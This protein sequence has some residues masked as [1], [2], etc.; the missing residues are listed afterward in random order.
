MKASKITS[1][2]VVESE[3][4]DSES[5]G[6]ESVRTDDFSEDDEDDLETD[7]FAK[8]SMAAKSAAPESGDEVSPA[9]PTTHTFFSYGKTSSKMPATMKIIFTGKIH[10]KPHELNMP[11]AY[12]ADEYFQYVD[13]KSK[14]KYRGLAHQLSG[15]NDVV[16]H[17]MTFA[18]CE[19]E[20]ATKLAGKRLTPQ[21]LLLLANVS[22]ALNGTID[23]NRAEIDLNTVDQ[24]LLA[25][26]KTTNPADKS[27]KTLTMVLSTKHSATIIKR[28]EEKEA[29]QKERQMKKKMKQS[30]IVAS[31]KP[32]P[33]KLDK[34][35]KDAPA[36]EAPI[37]ETKTAPRRKRKQ[38]TPSNNQ[39]KKPKSGIQLTSTVPAFESV[40]PFFQAIMDQMGVVAKQ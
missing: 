10:T 12:S 14:A 29:K 7:Q 18:N 4:S 40:V 20:I 3:D 38:E 1:S 28:A 5:S 27:K 37:K 30:S 36:K 22:N 32:S 35:A 33:A 23:M 17:I 21:I 2:R 19:L 11:L 6:D 9:K 24:E 31:A 15:S 16:H 13:T 39:P 26:F 34:D 25:G 8:P